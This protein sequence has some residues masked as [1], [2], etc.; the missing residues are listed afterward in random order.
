MRSKEK[1]REDKKGE[2][3]SKQ[4]REDSRGQGSTSRERAFEGRA[5][6]LAVLVCA[7]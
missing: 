2:K 5:F 6:R 1:R 3:G 4:K 7:H